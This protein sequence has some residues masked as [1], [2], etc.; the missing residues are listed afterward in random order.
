ME[1]LKPAVVSGAVKIVA[2]PWID[3]WDEA[4]ARTEMANSLKKTKNIVAVVASN[5]SIAK[6]AIDA[7]TEA[8]LAGKVAVSGQDAELGAC[9]RIVAGTQTMTVYKPLKP[10][11]RMAAGRGV[12]SGQWPADRQP[13]EGEQRQEGRAGAAARS[14]LGREEQHR[15]HRDQRRIPQQDEVYPKVGVRMRAPTTSQSLR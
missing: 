8:K 11:A 1:V 6:G 7:L 2:E 15:R 4:N 14:H 13:G 3:R 9:Q 12:E 5:D 10:L